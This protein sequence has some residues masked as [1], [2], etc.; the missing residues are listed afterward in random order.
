M[1]FASPKWTAPRWHALV[2][3]DSL[4]HQRLAISLLTRRGIQ[5]TAVNNGQQAVV[6][7]RDFRFNLILMDVEMPVLDGCAAT[8]QIRDQE[9]KLGRR[10]PIIAVTSMED[11]ERVL[12]A[13]MD[14]YISKP[15]SASA[16]DGVLRELL[17][18]TACC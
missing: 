8:R 15:L 6:A 2:A 17:A 3:E 9:T 7:A 4:L 16:L 10:V 12:R 1:L 18:E 14:A 13:G 11:P 5:A